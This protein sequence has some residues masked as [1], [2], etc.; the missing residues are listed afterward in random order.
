MFEYVLPVS[1]YRE[2]RR[3]A[4]IDEIDRP[5][6]CHT[7]Q[8]RPQCWIDGVVWTRFKEF[9]KDSWNFLKLRREEAKFIN[10]SGTF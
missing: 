7:S 1:S 5:D 2:S 10:L 9:S 3:N 6:P 8:S 4:H